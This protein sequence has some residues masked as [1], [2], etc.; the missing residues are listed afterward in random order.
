VIVDLAAYRN[1]VRCPGSLEISECGSFL[2]QPK[3]FVWLGLRAPSEAELSE[4]FAVF[5]IVE[6]TV[7]EVLRPHERAVLTRD[8]GVSALVIRT[9]HYNSRLEKVMLGEMSLIVSDSFIISVRHGQASPLSGVRRELEH[10]AHELLLGPAMVAASIVEQIVE[11]YQPVLDG[12]EKAAVGI[13][14]EVFGGSIGGRVSRH[15]YEL[16]RELRDFHLAVDALEDP[17]IRLLNRERSNWAPEIVDRVEESLDR[18]NRT[19]GRARSLFDLLGGAI[20]ANQAQIGVRQNEDMRKISAWVAIAAV[21]TMI[22]GIYGMN[23]EAMPELSSPIGYPI[24]LGVMGGACLFLYRRF[25]K[26][27]WL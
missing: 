16:R 22:A 5:G 19:I 10:E 26:A 11:D 4:A 15:I 24:I 6:P 8:H 1:G 18:L 13:E 12:F 3:T 21:P 27:G 9:A 7:G 2:A 14:A 25:R 20:D 17:L 23:F